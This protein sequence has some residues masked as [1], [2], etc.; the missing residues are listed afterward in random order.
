MSYSFENNERKDV[1]AD[2][3]IFHSWFGHHYMMRESCFRCPYRTISR[4]SDIV[5]GD[6]WGIE[7]IEPNLDVE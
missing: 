1:P 4:Y 2:R 3:N 6:F 5:I 7:S